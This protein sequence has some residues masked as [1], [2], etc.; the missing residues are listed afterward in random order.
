M[1][2]MT[3]KLP[4]IVATFVARGS[5]QGE[6]HGGVL[7]VDFEKQKVDLNTSKT[8]FDGPGGDR[9]LRGI[10]FSGNDILIA[11]SD[12]LFC[13]GRSFKIR[14]SSNNRYLKTAMKSVGWSERY[15]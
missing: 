7:L 5:W 2:R 15:S 10:A 14:T 6:S 13:C 11:G 8:V 3:S 9:G 12:E 4:T 1:Q